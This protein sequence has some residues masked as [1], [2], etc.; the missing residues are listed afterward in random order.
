MHGKEMPFYKSDKYIDLI[1]KSIFSYA[2]SKAVKRKPQSTPYLREDR[3]C[4]QAS[5]MGNKESTDQSMRALGGMFRQGARKGGALK[6]RAMR[7]SVGQAP[8]GHP[9][10]HRPAGCTEAKLGL[11]Y[12]DR[13]IGKTS[14][15]QMLTPSILDPSCQVLL[16]SGGSRRAPTPASTSTRLASPSW[17]CDDG[18][19]FPVHRRLNFDMQELPIE[20]KEDYLRRANLLM[21]SPDAPGQPSGGPAQV[22]S[23]PGGPAQVGHGIWWDSVGH[24]PGQPSAGHAQVGHPAQRPSVGGRPTQ[25]GWYPGWGGR[26][27][28]KR[29]FGKTPMGRARVGHAVGS[30]HCSGQSTVGQSAG[31]VERPLS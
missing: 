27:S 2:N 31:Q 9:S 25:G 15:F 28:K 7:A 16:L 18:N 12:M 10:G 23:H 11:D 22:G 26:V 6:K 14:Y 21:H 3:T 17:Y 8:V 5:K 20:L 24:A 30:G 1:H 13:V 19:V 29:G 4:A